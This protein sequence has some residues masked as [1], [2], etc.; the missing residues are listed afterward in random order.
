[1]RVKLD[2]H[3]IYVGAYSYI[4]CF[5]LSLETILQKKLLEVLQQLLTYILTGK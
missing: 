1:M 3:A 2:K 4:L 5:R